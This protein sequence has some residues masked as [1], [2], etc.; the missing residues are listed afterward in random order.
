MSLLSGPLM[1]MKSPTRTGR[2]KRRMKPEAMSPAMNCKPKPIP[3]DRAV[4][5]TASVV[6]SRL[7]AV[8]SANSMPSVMTR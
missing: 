6:R 5:T 2:S 4:K 7:K 3:T 8:L 1:V